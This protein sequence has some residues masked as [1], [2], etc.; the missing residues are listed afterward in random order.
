MGYDYRDW[1]SQMFVT[2]NLESMKVVLRK[3]MYNLK[4][5]VEIFN[6]SSLK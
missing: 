1:A 3:N 5:R 4:M 2:N 6:N